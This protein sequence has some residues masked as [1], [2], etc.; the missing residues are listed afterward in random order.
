M[1]SIVLR[2][3]CVLFITS[4]I[5][6]LLPDGKTGKIINFSL[7]VLIIISI[8]TPLFNIQKYDKFTINISSD[9]MAI[10]EYLD[11][12]YNMRIEQ[13]ENDISNVLKEYNIDVNGVL[14]SYNID[15]KNNIDVKKIEININKKVIETGNENIN[16][17][18]NIKSQISEKFNVDKKIIEVIVNE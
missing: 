4:I 13:V 16:I 17:I 11:Y 7:Y 1:N 6:L 14:V 10:N 12:L 15:D 3:F 8:L 9:N 5:S 18:E 2:F